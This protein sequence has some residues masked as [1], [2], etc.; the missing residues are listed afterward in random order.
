V[1]TIRAREDFDTA[2]SKAFRRAIRA[3]LTRRNPHLLSLDRV[4]A[5][6]GLEGKSFGGVREIPLDHVIGSAAAEVK[7]HDFDPGFL[8]VNRRLRDRWTR[9]YRAMVEGDELPPIDVYKL[10]DYYYVIDGHH[11]VSVARSLGRQ[12]INARVV[13]VKTRAPVG[14]HVDGAALLRAA[15]YSA[16]LES[17]QLHRTRPEARLECSRLGRYDEIFK[18]ILGHRYF[19]GLEQGREVPLAESAASWFDKVYMPVIKLIRKYRVLEL[20][21]GWTEADLY[22]EIT[23]RWLLLSEEGAPAG[24]DP[25]LHS[26]L[27]DESRSFWERRRS[28]KLDADP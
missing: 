27:D 20:M 1:E 3:A 28:L 17:T 4:L 24:P 14:S 23:R 2:R 15:E 21:P 5:A 25:A 26:L 10:D 19:L 9:I 13:D 22:V 8:P 16:F 18:H 6:A 12:E 11:R 7:G